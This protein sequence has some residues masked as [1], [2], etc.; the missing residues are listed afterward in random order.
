MIKHCIKVLLA[1]LVAFGFCGC[2]QNQTVGNETIADK[3]QL[4]EAIDKFNQAF[5][6][7]DVTTLET[8][9]T[10]Q[11]MHTNGNSKAIGKAS[12]FNYL[13][14]RKLEIEAGD[15]EVLSYNMDET[16]VKIYGNT[17]IF[18]ARITVVNSKK[19]ES[20]ENQYRVTNIWVYESGAW[21]RAG[22]H[23]GKIK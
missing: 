5:Q 17:A 1:F 10:D 7:G 12:W 9:I 4:M 19:G 22:F 6:Q 2:T 11:Y 20:V 14:K 3:G 8:M 23:D 13:N 21:K 16:D 15:L 18:T